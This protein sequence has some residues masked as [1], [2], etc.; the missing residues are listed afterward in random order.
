MKKFLSLLKSNWPVFSLL[1]VVIALF[2]TNYKT[3]TYLTGWDNLMPELDFGENIK[4]SLFAVWQEYQGLGLLGGMGHAADLPRQI[5]LAVSSVIIPQEL[6]RYL[7]TFLMLFIGSFGAYKLTGF[8]LEDEKEDK[9]LPFFAGLFYLLNLSTIQTFYAPFE[10]FT[11]HFAAL[12]WILFSALSYFKNPSKKNL[13]FLS[14]ITFL[15]TVQSYIPTLFVVAIIALVIV[16]LPLFSS[17]KKSINKSSKIFGIIFVI[18]AFWLL[19]FFYFTFTNASVNLNAKI[20]Q[21]ATDTIFLQ[22]KEFGNL[23]DVILIK[24]FW[25]NNTDPNLSGNFTYM[26]LPWRQYL[27][28]PLIQA[29]GFAIFGIILL[30]AYD[31]IRKPSKIK[32]SFLALFIFSFT[33]LATATF[34]FSWLDILFRKIPLFEQA[35]RFPFTKFS[36]L[37]SLS[38]AVLFSFGIQKLSEIIKQKKIIYLAAAI[39][40]FML[41]MPAFR[42]NLLYEKEA[43]KIPNEYFQMFSFF[44]NQDKNTRIANLPQPNFW[45]WT[46]YKWGYGG[47]GFIWYGITQPILDR[48]FDVWSAADENYYWEL[49]NALYSKNPKLV[50]NVLNKYQISWLIVDKNVINPQNPK[51]LF[52]PEIQTLLSQISS[53]NKSATYGNIDIYK[54]DLKDNPKNFIFETAKLPSANGASFINFDKAYKDLGNYETQRTADYFYPFRTLFSNKLSSQE[55]FSVQDTGEYLK[56]SSQIAKGNINISDYLSLEKISYADISL[57]YTNGNAVIS[58]NI[59]Q[60]QI[61]LDNKKI[62]GDQTQKDIFSIPQNSLFP[63]TIDINGL[64][65]IQVL[66]NQT[67]GLLAT[68]ILSNTQINVLTAVDN[69]GNSTPASISVPNAKTASPITNS[70]NGSKLDVLI[71]KITTNSIVFNP[72]ADIPTKNCDNFREGNVSLSHAS[73]ELLLFSSTNAAACAEILEANLDHSQGYLISAQTQNITGRPIHF[74]IL[75]EDE[76]STPIDTYFED[77]S[78]LHSENFVVPPMEDFGKSYSFH[79]ENQSIGNDKTENLL[80]KVYA[81]PIP[82][83]FLTSILINSKATPAPKSTISK[84]DV[85]HPN[86]SLY[87]INGTSS[88]TLILSQAY[89]SGWKA[90]EVKDINLLT[91]VFPFFFGKEIKNH[92]KIN[93]WE[94]GWSG[95]SG[96]NQ[97]IIIIYL[98]QYLEYFGFILTLFVPLGFVIKRNL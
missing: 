75:N 60:P 38:Y 65:K 66:K 35:F 56:F 23:S 13:I 82:Y 61:Y 26:F 92:M 78:V 55:E 34:P 42:G 50:E 76:K 3:G 33:M 19:P 51:V 30:G 11:G 40:I 57:K 8:A 98:P 44:K 49:S 59:K 96:N 6:L 54:A 93:N 48:A 24:G 72:Q 47:S 21:M 86:Q 81:Y 63:I 77:S 90:Y 41:I 36:I 5:F 74:W 79:F 67:P 58:T 14:L 27:S 39:A 17:L 7:W 91:Q 31:S 1:A 52:Y 43:I 68:V 70:K 12:P 69:K 22:N 53:V 2:I 9:F 84:L 97:S 80:G 15:S 95:L 32:A 71:P 18:N 94:N 62:W 87:S 88:D 73:K 4:R 85:S 46:F 25:F 20:N 45:G 83:N 29:L 28:N 64:Q 89:D 10:S 37:T 16:L